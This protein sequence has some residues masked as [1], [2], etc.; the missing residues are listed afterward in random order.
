S[1]TYDLNG[2]LEVE[3]TIVETR[4]KVSHLITRYARGLSQNQIEQAV[5]DMAKL[6]SHPRDEAVNRTLI[7]RAE[8]VFRELPPDDRTRLGMLLDGFEQSLAHRDQESIARHR[9]AIETFLSA[10]DSDDLFEME[11]EE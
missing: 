1:F 8:R 3:A 6:K 2:V 7:K 10:C 11:D 5:R 4:K 9:E